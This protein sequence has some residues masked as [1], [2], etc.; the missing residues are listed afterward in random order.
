MNDL[1]HE[2]RLRSQFIQLDDNPAA[3]KCLLCESTYIL[4]TNE[5]DFLTHIFKEHRLVIGDVEKIASL[6]RYLL[7]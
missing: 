3:T 4:P 1:S 7:L 5:K 2:S 6:K